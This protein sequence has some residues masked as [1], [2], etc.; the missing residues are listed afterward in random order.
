MT[1]NIKVIFSDLFGVL[2]GP[3]YTDLINYINQVTGETK[4]KIYQHVFDEKSMDYIR[5]A[6]SF[7]QYFSN[8]QYKIKHKM[9]DYMS[10]GLAV[11]GPDFSVR[12]SEILLS[13]DCGIV[14]DTMNL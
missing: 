6:I 10:A 14:V 7:S 11:I 8:V 9:F 3:D 1:H 13:S 5:G 2:V 4:E 12:I